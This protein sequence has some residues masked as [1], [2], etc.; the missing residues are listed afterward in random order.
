M[1]FCEGWKNDADHDHETDGRDLAAGLF[2]RVLC[3]YI[4]G[5]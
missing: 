3:S 2:L 4:H 1:L 5:I